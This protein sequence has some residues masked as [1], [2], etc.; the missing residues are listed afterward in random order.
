MN[1]NGIEVLGDNLID[2][3]NDLVS[4]VDKYLK[5]NFHEL[6]NENNIGLIF[7]KARDDEEIKSKIVNAVNRFIS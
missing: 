5:T 3:E 7:E 1:E 6:Y 2:S 4:V